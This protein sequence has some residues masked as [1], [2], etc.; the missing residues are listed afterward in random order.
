MPLSLEDYRD[1]YRH[2]RTRLRES[3]REDLDS[4]LARE[5]RPS[6]SPLDDLLTYLHRLIDALRERSQRGY[7][8]AL[9]LLQEY[10]DP[11]DA[12]EIQ[13]VEVF[14]TDPE[15]EAYGVTVIDLSELDD[16]SRLIEGL[17]SLIEDLRSE[18]QVG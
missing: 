12:N 14:L 13:G 2:L 1:I 18:P 4:L 7:H 11:I 16:Y 3:G 6:E 8:A 10:V 17:E 9:E 15:Q 5:F